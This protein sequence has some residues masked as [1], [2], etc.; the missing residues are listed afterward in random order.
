MDRNLIY[1]L[2]ISVVIVVAFQAVYQHVYPPPPRK[3]LTP[4]ESTGPKP[5]IKQQEQTKAQEKLQEQ[6]VASAPK[7]EEPRRVQPSGPEVRL[8]VDTPI[9]EAV[10]SSSGGRFISFKLK[11]FSV[12]NGKPSGSEN[13][14]S[15]YDPSGPDTG[16]PTIMLTGHS[17]A[18]G[19]DDLGYTIDLPPG[20][21]LELISP[22]QTKSV[23]LRA[24]NPNGI[25]IVKTFTF[26]ADL[27]SIGVSY[28]LTNDNAEDKNYL[29]TFPWRKAYTGEDK[30]AQFSWNSSEILIN[31]ELKDYYFKDIKGD[32][33]PAGKV[34][35]ASLGDKYFLNALAFPDRPAQR[36]TLFKPGTEGFVKAWVRYGPVDLPSKKTVKMNLV[37]YLGP[38]EDS[39]LRAAGYNLHRAMMYSNNY[40][41]D[42]MA[43]YLMQFL[44]LCNT[45]TTVLGIKIPGTNNYGIDI[46]I[47]TILIKILFI[48]LS[49]K[50]MK[51][52][53]RMQELQPQM[54]K[55]KEKFKDD[56]TALNK[57]TMDLFK[58]HRVSPLGGCWP[59]FLQI[60]VF[61]A[62]YQ[63][64][65]WAIELRHAPFMCMPSIYLC[66]NDLAAPDPYYI[67]PILMGGTMLLQQWM[68]PSAGDPTQRKMMML[69]PVFFTYIFLSFP[70]GLV[71]YWLVSNVL[72]IAQQYVTN[73][74]A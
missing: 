45:G 50:S 12:N 32:E 6:P 63:A 33:E 57:A 62:L 23:S 37:T 10:L 60:P 53:K 17:A 28:E 30:N 4:T 69:M 61:I 31:G 47:L 26:Q 39:A 56:K 8:K 68:T 29:V 21:S 7:I 59:M 58:E 73:R 51:S 42:L 20:G 11:K 24:T 72:S 40:V 3:P 55:L 34:E 54:A 14:V 65:S 13:L 64:L 5:P 48:P 15:L 25:N 52:M 49:H 46:I 44:R 19:D 67:T 74:M 71:L 70:S 18:F 9:Y 38:K 35:W 41:L 43:T 27:Y 66:L 16:G 22:G 2:I 36:V 1:A